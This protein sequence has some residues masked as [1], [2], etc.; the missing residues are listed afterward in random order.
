MSIKK[1]A[2]YA[3]SLGSGGV[4]ALILLPFLRTDAVN[5]GAHDHDHEDAAAT[6]ALPVEA[7]LHEIL[8]DLAEQLEDGSARLQTILDLTALILD[9]TELDLRTG[10]D[11]IRHPV[12]WNAHTFGYLRI[13]GQ[14]PNGPRQWIF[15]LTL[16]ALSRYGTLALSSELSITYRGVDGSLTLVA[17]AVETP[18]HRCRSTLAEIG[19]DPFFVGAGLMVDADSASWQRLWTQVSVPEATG[20]PLWTSGQLPPE[21]R[22][23]TLGAADVTF[24]SSA[25]FSL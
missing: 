7:P 20:I 16:P 23:D 2:C 4:G 17:A 18:L 10:T 1:V 21:P 5:S 24:V 8:V 19:A 6:L 11:E 25:L 13:P 3:L 9:S 12:V 15:E 22:E 14:Q